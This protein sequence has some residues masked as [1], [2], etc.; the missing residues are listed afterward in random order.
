MKRVLIIL[1]PNLNVVG[2]RERGI[3]G[4]DSAQTINEETK[5]YAKKLGIGCEIF[6]SN[7]E[8]ALID[9]IHGALDK[10]DGLI[11]NAG[12]LSHYSISL[13]DALAVL[14]IPIIEVHMSN[15]FAREEFRHKSV[16]SAVCL[17]QI[18]GFGKKVYTLAL[19]AIN[20]LI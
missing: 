4:N 14:R 19:L 7:S 10:F 9:K 18:V 13:R 2:I 6:Q 8:G 1:G 5:E 15:I 16:I 12:A 17:G 20:D 11:I 3:Y